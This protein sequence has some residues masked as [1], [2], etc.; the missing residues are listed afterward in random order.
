MP[1]NSTQPTAWLEDKSLAAASVAR[2]GASACPP[3]PR[4]PPPQQ[5]A[6]APAGQLEPPQAVA[7]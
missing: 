5:V 2:Q 7:L 6:K 4:Q 1:Q 3:A